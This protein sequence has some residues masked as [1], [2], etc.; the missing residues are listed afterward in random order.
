MPLAIKQMLSKLHKLIFKTA[1][2]SISFNSKSKEGIE[3]L[4]CV[5]IH[6]GSLFVLVEVIMQQLPDTSP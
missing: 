1:W 2:S 3:A 6:G 5:N 4:F